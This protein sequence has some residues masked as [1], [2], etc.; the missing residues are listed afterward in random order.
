MS[1]YRCTTQ[2]EVFMPH[3]TEDV[4]EVS[5]IL[6]M[7]SLALVK[8]EPAVTHSQASVLLIE[9]LKGKVVGYLMLA[10]QLLKAIYQRQTV[11]IT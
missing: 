6:L 8:I 7:I 2:N 9:L 1:L 3:L 10:Y 11:T 5:S 4:L